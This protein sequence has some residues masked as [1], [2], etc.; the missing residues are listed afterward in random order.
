MDLFHQNT[1]AQLLITSTVPV[2]STAW[3]RL[4]PKMTCYVSNGML[5]T[6]HYSLESL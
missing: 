5:N 2:Q 3:K 6:T 1:N 4:I